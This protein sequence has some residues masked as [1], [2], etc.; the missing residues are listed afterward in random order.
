MDRRS[1]HVTRSKAFVGDLSGRATWATG[2]RAVYPFLPS[3]PTQFPVL[4]VPGAAALVLAVVRRAGDEIVAFVVV[5]VT[6]LTTL[7]G[8]LRLQSQRLVDW[9]LLPLHATALVYAAVTTWSLCRSVAHVV[10][11]RLP[12]LHDIDP[13]WLAGGGTALATLL[14]VVIVPNLHEEASTRD[15]HRAPQALVQA[16]EREVPRSHTV[17]LDAPY[18]SDG[19]FAESLALDLDRAGYT[20]RYPPR[21][22]YLFTDALTALPT[23]RPV[24]VLVPTLAKLPLAPPVPGAVALG[25]SPPGTKGLPPGYRYTVWR[26]PS[27]APSP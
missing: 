15:M 23:G 7:L 17:L 8:L 16:V 19:Y 13:R 1:R 21:F 12:L 22:A 27:T 14:A 3:P 2:K 9:Y 5:G 24:T 11:P 20:V 18:D 4:L 25:T 26:I 10:R 6:M